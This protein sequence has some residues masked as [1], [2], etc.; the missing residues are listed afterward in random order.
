MKN[1]FKC[2]I[3]LL[4]LNILYYKISIKYI[5]LDNK[6]YSYENDTDFSNYK[7]DIKA[8]AFYTPFN[9]NW[10]NIINRKPL[11]KG[12]HQPRIPED[13]INYL[14]TYKMENKNVL[15]I[16]K[17]QVELAKRHGLY[18]FAIYFHWFSGKILFQEFFNM[19]INQDFNFPFFFIWKN[20]NLD[21]KSDN[22]NQENIIIKQEYKDKDPDLFIKDI[23]R[24]LIE[25]LYIKIDNKPIIGI[26]YPNKIP[27]LNETIK[28]W[29]EKSI[30][31]GIGKIYILINF[32][33][34]LV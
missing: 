14:G 8:I 6:I 23:K 19:L 3:I 13:N 7:T 34:F 10:I 30:E 9:N 28:I 15:K 22:S 5:Q 4:I 25:P 26:L 12:N 29:R 33:K 17:K 31:Y 21:I 20:E 24:F 2:L 18:G 27:K 11:Y 32:L 1:I 16:F